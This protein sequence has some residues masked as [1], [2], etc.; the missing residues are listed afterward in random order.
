M[1][2]GSFN[3]PGDGQIVMTLDNSYSLLKAK[4]VAYSFELLEQELSSAAG[5]TNAC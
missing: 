1:Q 3:C 4:V 5:I 2:R